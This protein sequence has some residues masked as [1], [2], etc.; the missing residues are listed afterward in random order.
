MSDQAPSSPAANASNDHKSRSGATSALKFAGL[1]LVGLAVLATA[2]GVLFYVSPPGWLARDVI[3]RAVAEKTGRTLTVAG[4]STLTLRPDVKLR[5]DKVALSGPPGAADQTPVTADSIEV[6]I[7]I[8]DLWRRQFEVPEL[9][10]VKPLITLIAGDPI[11]AKVA[12]G[13]VR[14][15]G[16]PQ[17]VVLSEG[18]LVVKAAPPAETVRLEGI[19][20]T[21]TRSAD[22]KGLAFKGSVLLKDETV[23]L[24][25]NVADIYALGDGATSSLEATVA[26]AGTSAVFKGD[27]ATK[28]AGQ[29]TGTIAAKS[30]D[31]DRLL[32]WAGIEPG[33][34]KLGKSAAIDGKV[35]GSLRRLSLDPATVTLAGASGVVSGVVSI[36][37]SRPSVKATVREARIDLNQLLPAATDARAFSLEPLE[38]RATL[39]S[40]WQSLL[41][42]LDGTPDRGGQAR[43]AG[44][45]AAPVGGWSSDPFKLQ[46]LP[47]MDIDLTIEAKEIRYRQIPMSG[48]RLAVVSKPEALDVVVDGLG[49]YKGKVSGTA[50]VA[51]D[52]GP[53]ASTVKLKMDAVALEPFMAEL[54]KQRLVAGTGDVDVTVAGRGGSMRELVGS[55]DGKLAFE[56]KKGAIIGYDLRRALLSFGQAQTYNAERRTPFDSVTGAYS[57]KNGV[58]RSVAETKLNGPEVD[59]WLSGTLALVS[60]RIDQALKLAL[61]PPPLAL[62]IPLKVRGTTDEP[63][64]AW[65]IFSAV[66]EP[67]TFATPFAVGPAEERMPDDVRQAIT[68]RL[69]DPAGAP[70]SPESRRFLEELLATR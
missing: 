29:V 11:L 47:E 3:I 32:T 24:D 30:E 51:V 62:P 17:R 5:L 68:A 52:K 28:P 41:E 20:G 59:V 44:A 6:D 38:G 22:E 63:A 60:R 12:E 25:G 9:R 27:I 35:A 26:V 46:K 70:L 18:T 31:L 13:E 42:G 49:L 19:T 48:G 58:L 64:F 50:N 2:V 36:E 4:D 1:L 21:V 69:A 15:G 57:I 65:D 56:A 14:A 45:V 37:E 23:G 55:L 43:S 67:Q 53:L 66:A 39:P 33:E 16:I 54:L 8:L 34:V 40:A 61:K 10:L 7:T